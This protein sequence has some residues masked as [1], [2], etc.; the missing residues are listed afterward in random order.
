MKTTFDEQYLRRVSAMT[1]TERDAL[2]TG[3]SAL[4]RVVRHGSAPQRS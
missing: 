3:L 1:R 2:L 4:V